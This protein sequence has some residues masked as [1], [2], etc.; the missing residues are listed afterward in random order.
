MSERPGALDS[1]RR[2]PKQK[3]AFHP[4][5][6][7]PKPETIEDFPHSVEKF[8]INFLYCFQWARMRAEILW[9]FR[10]GDV[11]QSSVL[12]GVPKRPMSA[13]ITSGI[14][15]NLAIGILLTV[16]TIFGTAWWMAEQHDKQANQSL[17]RM[18]VGGVDLTRRRLEAITNDYGWWEEAYLAYERGDAEWMDANIG[19]GITG[20]QIADALAVVTA[21][22]TVG[23][24]WTVDETPE[25]WKAI[26]TPEL[27]ARTGKL[28][29]DAKVDRL[30]ARSMFFAIA[31]KVY[32]IAV[33]RITPVS[34]AESVK[35]TDLPLVVF[36]QE[37]T[38]DRLLE[39]GRQ[40]LIS[41]LR[42]GKVPL[43]VSGGGGAHGSEILDDADGKPV[44]RLLWTSP[45]PGRDLL[46][47][48]AAPM[49][50][51]L[52]AFVIVASLISMRVRGMALALS[53]SEEEAIGASRSDSQTGLLNRAG[54]NALMAA[55]DCAERCRM[56]Q[57]VVAYLDVNDFK[58]VNDT[59]GHHGGDQVIVELAARLEKAVGGHG[60]LARIGG[61][62]FMILITGPDVVDDMARLLQRLGRAMAE[63][64]MAGSFI[65]HV[66]CAIG[67]A[68]S[69]RGSKDLHESL[70]RADIAMYHA[71]QSRERDGVCYEAS[72][73]AGNEERRR[74]EDILRAAL[75]KGELSVVYQPILNLASN[76]IVR[77]EALVR[78]NSAIHGSIRPDVFIPVAETTGL[79]EEV[80]AF[81]LEQ[82]CRDMAHFPGLNVSV[83][84]SPVQ[85]RD[86][87]FVAMLT[88][89][90]NK[91]GIEPKRLE[92]ELTE[93]VLVAAP[94]IAGQRLRALR[95]LGFTLALD[96]FGTGFS[97]IGYLGQFPFQCLKI[98][99]SFIVNLGRSVKDAA[100][101][102][103]LV[104]LCR[105]LDLEVVAEG[106]ESDE[107][108][109]ML[110]SVGCTAIQGYFVSKPVALADLLA[111]MAEW[112]KRQD[113]STEPKVRLISAR[114]PVKHTGNA[115]G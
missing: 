7:L 23:T 102:H 74:V 40:Y 58:A 99:R 113:Q 51:A 8:D 84:I 25:A 29:A 103:S 65:Q 52:L 34:K 1:E 61:D 59:I 24:A 13:G 48:L 3:L 72:M 94:L 87:G 57:A 47:Q 14:T 105:A 76:R 62:E 45:R 95:E 108:R 80:G 35:G 115:M 68:F 36:A 49:F 77:A 18:V 54:I 109:V 71:K 83:N 31:G 30:A 33:Q 101:V 44:G 97:S 107:H 104:S 46:L 32:L 63:P 75:Q 82:A 50:G 19:T 21:D 114:H 106:V 98:D 20:T 66:H 15:A 100:L 92:L 112:S 79:I 37:M 42:L 81:V 11:V 70:R 91:Y 110:R 69:P 73:E 56:G 43:G 67:Y 9:P 10:E 55:P 27:V 16:V 41:N 5:G 6:R 17:E 38:A 60:H 86:P 53:Q 93:G 26:F 90:V 22:G 96:D 88:G 89:T 39:L 78:L 2:Q 111:F 85:L 28:I 4:G 12:G 64:F